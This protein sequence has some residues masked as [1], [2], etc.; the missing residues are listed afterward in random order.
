V[1]HGPRGPTSY[2]Y[3]LPFYSRVLGL[4]STLS[5]KLAQVPSL[6]FISKRIEELIDR[7]FCKKVFEISYLLIVAYSI[8]IFRYSESVVV[9]ENPIVEY[10]HA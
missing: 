8:E 2:F 3:M 1:A 7:K 5:T 6:R 10:F 4:T 9:S